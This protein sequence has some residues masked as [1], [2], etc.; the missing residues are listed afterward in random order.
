MGETHPAASK[1]VLEFTSTDLAASLNLTPPQTLKL[2]KLLGTRYNHLTDTARM[3]CERFD[4]AAQNKRYLGDLLGSLVKEARE[5]KDL[6]EDVPRDDR[7]VKAKK[8]VPF[9][10]AWLLNE[11]RVKALAK[12]RS[13][14]GG[15]LAQQQQQRNER[16]LEGQERIAD[17]MKKMPLGRREGPMGQPVSEAERV[18]EREPVLVR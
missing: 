9:P 3:S 8:K 11:G 7:H 4:H 14:K 17:F 18:P 5:G 10:D 1:V 12:D 15:L 13:T 16:D 2:T 6:F